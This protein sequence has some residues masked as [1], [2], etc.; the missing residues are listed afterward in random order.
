MTAGM[1]VLLLVTCS[2][3][4]IVAVLVSLGG[5]ERWLVYKERQAKAG[6]LNALG[7]LRARLDPA[8]SAA[9]MTSAVPTATPTNSAAASGSSV[10][11]ASA[12]D[13][14]QRLPEMAPPLHEDQAV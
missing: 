3:L 9:V 8:Y 6:A 2:G 1:L 10:G 11:C 12:G 5:V 4:V 14:I 7:P 13:S